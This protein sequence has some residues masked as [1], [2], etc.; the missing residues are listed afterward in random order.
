MGVMT[1][2]GLSEIYNIENCDIPKSTT[3]LIDT[4][5]WYFMTYPNAYFQDDGA[6]AKGD[7]YSQFV[8]K[9]KNNSNKLFFSMINYSELINIIERNEY[10]IYCELNNKVNTQYSRKKYRREHR[11]E[12]FGTMDNVLKQV[13]NISDNDGFSQKLENIGIREVEKEFKETL[14]D[15]SDV[16][17]L[18]LSKRNNILNILTDDMDFCST[19]GMKIFTANHFH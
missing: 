14:L 11:D 4:N 5:I 18:L 6:I 13:E 16:L 10:K 8:S 7:K 3:F 19:K 9:L 2:S 17:N 12:Y 15:P 1:V